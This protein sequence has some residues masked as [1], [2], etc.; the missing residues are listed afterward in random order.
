MNV[1]KREY[2]ECIDTLILLLS[3]LFLTMKKTFVSF[4]ILYNDLD[5][6]IDICQLTSDSGPED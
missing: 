4:R 3:K 1:F 5:E 6:S 2:C